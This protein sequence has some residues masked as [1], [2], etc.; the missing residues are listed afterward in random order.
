[1]ADE[2]K[3]MNLSKAQYTL[4]RKLYLEMRKASDEVIDA[5]NPLLRLKNIYTRSFEPDETEYA[6][7]NAYEVIELKKRASIY[8]WVEDDL[9]R[10]LMVESLKRIAAGLEDADTVANTRFVEQLLS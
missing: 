1:M 9:V 10:Q 3:K 4:F 2:R 5:E 7:C 6:D 8:K